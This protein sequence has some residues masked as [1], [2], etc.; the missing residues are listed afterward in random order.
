MNN[1]QKDLIK[2]AAIVLTSDK[3]KKEAADLKYTMFENYCLVSVAKDIYEDE[4]DY[5]TC[6]IL[7]DYLQ[8]EDMQNIADNFQTYKQDWQKHKKI[9]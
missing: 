3:T 9:F 1:K 7:R 6:A 5:E 4:E 2:L 8:T